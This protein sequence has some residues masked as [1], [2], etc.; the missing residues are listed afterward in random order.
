MYHVNGGHRVQI[1]IYAEEN[2]DQHGFAAQV[3]ETVTILE[4][5]KV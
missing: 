1:H 2:V 4:E 3:V 5:E